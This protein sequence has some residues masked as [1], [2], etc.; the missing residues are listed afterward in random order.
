MSNIANAFTHGPAFIGFV[1]AGDPSLEKTEEF[2][3]TMERAGADLIEIGIPFSDPVA[4]GPVIQRA[5]ARALAAGATTD[6][7]FTMVEN[8]RLKTEIPLVFL[9]YL[10]PV[11]KYGYESFVRRC[12]ECGVDGLI[13]PDLPFEERD[14]LGAVCANY[15]IDLVSLIAPT[16]QDRIAMI[17]KHATGFVYCVSSMG[18]TGIRTSITSDL[19]GMV[20]AIKAATSTPVAV[21]FG[22]STPAQATTIAHF[23]DGIIVGSAIVKIV[24]E[25]GSAANEPLFE[26]ISALKSA[27][28]ME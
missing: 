9:T 13:I 21:G 26:Y 12:Q 18:V 16:S 28:I 15:D 3:L 11:F 27:T 19:E 4:E 7:I 1:T 24:E 20:T 14:E 8:V 5:N 2:I 23:A 10:N 6:K 25:H 22:I 17:A